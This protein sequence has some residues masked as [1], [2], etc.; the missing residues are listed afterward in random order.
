M[1]KKW[2]NLHVLI[3]IIKFTS[4]L[5]PSG[6]KIIMNFMHYVLLPDNFSNFEMLGQIIFTD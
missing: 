3:K 2:D 4:N 6:G 1:K 5:Y